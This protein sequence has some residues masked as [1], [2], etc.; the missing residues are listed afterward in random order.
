MFN[1]CGHVS[2]TLPPACKTLDGVNEAGALQINARGTPDTVDDWCY[3]V[4]SSTP[5]A[6]TVKLL[7][8]EDPTKGVE[9]TY[10]G[11]YCNGGKQRKFHIQMQCAD[12][13]NAVPTHALELEPCAYTVTMPSV[14]GCPLECPVANRKLCGG[15][16]H[17]AYDD[18]KE[19]A[20]CFCNSGKLN[21]CCLCDKLVE[22]GY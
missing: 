19:G 16:G 3:L 4:G 22:C 14:Y 8:S 12:K 9:V 18:D 17:C 1:V 15:N 13:L 11:S 6:T 20:R 21:I 10:A 5:S 2:G 7:N